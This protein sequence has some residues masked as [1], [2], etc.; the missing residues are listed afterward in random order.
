MTMSRF[1]VSPRVSHIERVKRIFSYLNHYKNA[2]I[3]FNT[4]I[5]DYSYFDQQWSV[6]E[7]GALYSND[8]GVYDDP[9]LPE[10]KGNPIIMTTYV[11]SN[12]L[13][14]YIMG[15]SCTGV[16]HLFN[17]TVMDWFLKIQNNVETATYGS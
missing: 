17:K 15:R 10:P 7:W 2:S 3:K 8:D 16:I 4:E 1:Q 12:L 14:D 13:H 11:D 6:P 5:P 9:K